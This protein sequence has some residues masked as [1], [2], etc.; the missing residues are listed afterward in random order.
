MC[1][2][3]ISIKEEHLED[4]VSRDID[5]AKFDLA[6]A[7]RDIGLAEERYQT[8]L[9]CLVE[10]YAKK[11]R[12]YAKSNPLHFGPSPWKILSCWDDGF[13]ENGKREYLLFMFTNGE[14]KK[15]RGRPNGWL[16]LRTL[17]DSIE[18]D[19]V[20]KET[21]EYF[22]PF[23]QKPVNEVV[24]EALKSIYNSFPKSI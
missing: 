7:K 1:N 3:G 6:I 17:E 8:A 15:V 22:D 13:A 5:Y 24:C 9:V 11:I 23:K 4:R 16:S 2:R 10:L 20:P 19:F 12:N 14:L 18:G 21:K